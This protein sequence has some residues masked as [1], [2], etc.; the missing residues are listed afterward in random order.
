VFPDFITR[1][2]PTGL[3]GLVVAAIFAAAMS[4]SLNSIAAAFVADLYRPVVRA[5]SDRHLLRVSHIA[6]VVAGIVQIAVGLGVRHQSESALNTALGIASLINGP[7]L[8]VFLLGTLR[9]GGRAAALSGMTV[10]LAVVLYVRFATPIAWPWYTVIGSLTT[11]IV[12]ASIAGY[13]PAGAR[14]TSPRS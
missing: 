14:A 5:A 8:G 13:Q 12:G 9:R 6:T 4:S 1:H 11:L 7:I 10:G 3:S 2:L